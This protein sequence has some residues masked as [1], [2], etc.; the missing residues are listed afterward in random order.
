MPHITK[1][2]I[3]AAKAMNAGDP[4]LNQIEAHTWVQ[5]TKEEIDNLAL[6][7]RLAAAQPDLV[8]AGVSIM[9][10]LKNYLNADSKFPE[11]REAAEK[12]DIVREGQLEIDDYGVVSASDE[13]AYIMGWVWVP[14]ELFPQRFADDEAEEA[15]DV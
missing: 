15:A 13:G 14:N 10:K 12:V 7:A 5:F 8:D 9:M 4:E 3:A 1:E 6:L 11:F 2:T